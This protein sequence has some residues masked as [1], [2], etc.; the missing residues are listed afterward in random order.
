MKNEKKFLVKLAKAGK[1]RLVEPSNNVKQSYLE[2]SE[3]NLISSKILLKNNRLE[4][5]VSLTYYSMYNLVLAL[6]FGVGIKCVNHLA[7]TILLKEVFGLD[8]SLLIQAKEERI[9]KQYYTDFNITKKEV[10]EGIAS[11]ENFNR[12]LRAFILSL[13]NEKISDYRNKF[14]ELSEN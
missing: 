9:D 13:N 3:S 14:L 1:L 7:A 11:A 8:N 6:L 2:K 5:S 12:D 4:E 10:E